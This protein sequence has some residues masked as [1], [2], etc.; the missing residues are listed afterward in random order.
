MDGVTKYGYPRPAMTDDGSTGN[1]CL[2]EREGWYCT[3]PSGHTGDHEAGV[4]SGLKT[5]S[6]PQRVGRVPA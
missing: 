6:W 2:D 1:Y 3:R 5:A 4:G